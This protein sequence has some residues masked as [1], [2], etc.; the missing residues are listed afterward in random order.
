MASF[1]VSQSSRQTW[2][3]S[4]L[5]SRSSV[6]YAP[7]RVSTCLRGER[8]RKRGQSAQNLTKGRERV[9]SKSPQVVRGAGI[10]DVVGHHDG[11]LGDKPGL[12]HRDQIG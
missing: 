10:D 11:P 8:E 7:A 12:L 5:A 4:N 9:G 1:G 3:Y 2:S 6:L